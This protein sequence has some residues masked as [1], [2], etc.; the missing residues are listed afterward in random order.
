MY[1]LK[2]KLLYVNMLLIL[3]MLL[4]LNI[5]LT[6]KKKIKK[7]FIISMIWKNS[8]DYSI[9]CFYLINII[10]YNKK[11]IYSNILSSI[12]LILEDETDIPFISTIKFI[13]II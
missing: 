9:D 4:T 6:L 1:K 5:L 12:S 3:N 13:F 11:I 2:F 7:S 8:S 10:E